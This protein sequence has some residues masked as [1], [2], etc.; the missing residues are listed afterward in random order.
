MTNSQNLGTI[1]ATNPV[2]A[3]A[4]LKEETE[5]LRATEK[6]TAL[7]CRLSQEDA[8]EGDSNSITNQKDILLRY[9]KEH[10][11][12]NPTFFVD[13]GYSGTNYDRPGFQQMLSEIEAGKVVVVLTKDLSRLGRNSSLTGLYINFTFPKYSVR[14]IA[15]NDHFDTID[16][17]STDNDVAGIKN[18]FNEFFA[19][20]TSRKIRAVQKA[21]GERGVPLTTNV[22]FGYR[23]DPE[24]RTKWIVDEAA[25]LV[26]KRIFKL[27]MEGR[28]PMQIAKLLQA[29][30][31]LNPT[32]YKRRE[33]IK[34]PSPETADPYHW[35]TNTVVHILERRE[36]TGC[37]V[38][39][40]TYT[41]SIWDKKQR[42]TPLD[43]QAVFYNTH[44]AIIEQEVFDKVQQIRKQRHRRTKTGKSSLFSGMVYCA[45]CGAKMRYCTTNYF[46]KRQDHFVCANYRSNTGSCSAHFIRAVV[47]EELVWMHMKAVIFYVTRYEKHFRT[48]MEQRLRMSS[49]EAIRGY[50]TQFAQAERRLAELDRLFIRI[51][52]DNVS[53][54]ITDERFSMMSRTYEDEQTQ[55]KV[56]IQSLQQEIEVQERQIENL[57][58]FIQRVHKYEDLQELT[59]YALRE[60]V[61][62][63]YIEAPDKSSGKRRQ[64]IRISYDLVGFIPLNELVKEETA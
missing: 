11:F 41:N 33:G 61:K 21:K 53:G 19:K 9:A 36:Y 24:D 30:K 49:E 13:D 55:L 5:M 26:V 40:K 47:L 10:R 18:W 64:N 42:E 48:V 3:V 39:F 17:N 28:G 59:P 35:N 37:T 22:P 43:K 8:N 1:E 4:P 12:P 29:E 25:A 7:Y 31:V 14:Y 15:I 52:E 38:N 56:E 16:P 6:I 62:A 2:L 46:E 27:C 50:K 60:L 58:Q 45:D 32:S 51:Y 34:S 20:D 44:P 57:E 54:R 23:K 63:I